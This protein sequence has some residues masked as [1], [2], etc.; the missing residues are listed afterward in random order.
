M[1]RIRNHSFVLHDAVANRRYR[2]QEED[3]ELV[4]RAAECSPV[5]PRGGK[6]PMRLNCSYFFEQRANLHDFQQAD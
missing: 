5:R 2:K 4:V 6:G 1:C 3:D